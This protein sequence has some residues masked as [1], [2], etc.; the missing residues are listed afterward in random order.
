MLPSVDLL[1]TPTSLANY[2]PKEI[3]STALSLVASGFLFLHVEK[4][5]AQEEEHMAA[6]QQR[7]RSRS[8]SR[9]DDTELW[10]SMPSA[11]RQEEQLGQGR[12]TE[13]S[14][15][16]ATSSRHIAQRSASPSRFPSIPL[17]STTAS[18][19]KPLPPSPESEK[20]RRKPASLRSLIRR[21]P[22]DQLDPSHLHPASSQNHQ[23]S[24]SAN[25]NLAPDSYAYFYQQTS[26]RSMPSSPA[27]FDQPYL[28][29]I[30]LTRAQSA[31]A[32]CPESP[33]YQ[34]S[35]GQQEQQQQLQL[36]Q[37]TTPQ[38]A[39]SMNTYFEPPRTRRTFPEAGTPSS[40]TP[41]DGVQERPR[42]HTWL[43][44][45]TESQP[46]VDASEFH[47]FA[48]ATVGFSDG[49]LSFDGLSPS[50][51]PHLQGS[52]FSRGRQN[53][54]IPL[55]LANP[56]SSQSRQSYYQ[57]NSWQPMSYDYPGAAPQ[58]SRQQAN[59]IPRPQSY[60][61]TSLAPSMNAINLELE[62]LGLIDDEGNPDD[63]LPDYAQSQAE[64]SAK[65]R[66]EA[67]ARARELEARWNSSRGGW[68]SR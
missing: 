66:Q 26:S 62:R 19:N 34:Y 39:V 25:G 13:Q 22:S 36:P 46:L 20:K 53:D 2:K 32:D 11:S 61:Q 7:S 18:V 50:S 10:F 55:P 15:Y 23:R 57:V 51:P 8:S 3:S 60:Q 1:T 33:L 38:R 65:K 58:P 52:L 43:S 67:T 28:Q 37:Q 16:Q 35:P 48:A 41:N 9:R 29:P 47:L 56:A 4:G 12:G 5:L 14:A 45:T 64:M 63:E 30:P 54:S 40:A 59:N 24:S 68:R 17:I 49:G 6:P 42:P 21:R 31:G 44:P 27:P